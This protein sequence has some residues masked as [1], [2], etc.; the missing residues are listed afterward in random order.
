MSKNNGCYQYFL[1][2]KSS[3]SPN[4]QK[5]HFC[6]AFFQNFF[7][8]LKKYFLFPMGRAGKRKK[9]NHFQKNY[10]SSMGRAPESN[11]VNHFQKIPF[12]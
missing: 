11:F 1:K 2:K 12:T 8:F 9:Y 5:S 3:P 6:T 7:N 4:V 10:F